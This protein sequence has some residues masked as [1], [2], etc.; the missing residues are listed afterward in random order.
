MEFEDAVSDQVVAPDLEDSVQRVIAVASSPPAFSNDLS[1]VSSTELIKLIGADTLRNDRPLP[2]L[3]GAR[4]VGSHAIPTVLLVQK[5]LSEEFRHLCGVLQDQYEEEIERMKKEYELMEQ[6]IR[7]SHLETL[8]NI[9]LNDVGEV[10]ATHQSIKVQATAS[11]E[12]LEQKL[13]NSADSAGSGDIRTKRLTT[14]WKSRYQT[15]AKKLSDEQQRLVAAEAKLAEQVKLNGTDPTS[16]G[17]L[18]QT[19]RDVEAREKEK[20]LSARSHYARECQRQGVVPKE[21]SETFVPIA[22]K[23]ETL[24]GHEEAKTFTLAG[25]KSSSVR[26]LAVLLEEKMLQ[27]GAALQ[28]ASSHEVNICS[29]QQQLDTMQTSF[30]TAAGTASG[31]TGQLLEEVVHLRAEV[32]L[33]DSHRY[34]T[35]RRALLDHCAQRRR[36]SQLRMDVESARCKLKER[37]IAKRKELHDFEVQLFQ[38]RHGGFD[39]ASGPEMQLLRSKLAVLENEVTLL[40]NERS[41]LEKVS[42]HMRTTV[43]GHSQLRK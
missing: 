31:N 40:K 34:S 39:S 14:F 36:I 24:S 33:R 5:R 41:D 22:G 38:L 16:L 25:S 28:V 4:N 42:V 26:L 21:I 23:T 11:A 12:L 1:S 20:L 8:K 30:C 7:S 6:T 10:S 32:E 35:E 27:A 43:E 2:P 29:L 13:L 18:L 9:L 3:M 17:H 15:T 37:M 19:L